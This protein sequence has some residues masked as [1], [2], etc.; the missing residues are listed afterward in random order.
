MRE[1]EGGKNRDNTT[2]ERER[3]RERERTVR[4]CNEEKVII[5]R[6][7]FREK[8]NERVEIILLERVKNSE[9]TMKETERE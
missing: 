8:G 2:R 5:Q 9:I 7:W 4:Y 3:E 6:E 1:R